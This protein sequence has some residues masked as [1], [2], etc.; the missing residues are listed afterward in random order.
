MFRT[1]A[2]VLSLSLAHVAGACGSTTPPTT[3]QHQ[4]NRPLSVAEHMAEAARHDKVAREHEDLSADEAESAAPPIQC[5]DN[6]LAPP[7]SSGGKQLRILRPCWTSVTRPSARH[8]SEA[9]EN[10]REAE[11]HRRAAAQ[12]IGAEKV[13]CAGLGVEATNHSPFYHREDIEGAQ[14][15][16][17][18]GELRGARVAFR[19][20][21]GLNVDWMRRAS[22]CHIARAGVMGYS[23]TFMPYCP[24]VIEGVVASV[25]ERAGAIEVELR[26]DDPVAAATIWGRV[27]RLT[28]GS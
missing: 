1:H 14:P 27:E 6:P 26:A 20:V 10:R 25:T 23:K 7:S 18:R 19:K 22:A 28:S 9:E 12:L 15:I 2:L 16:R 24:L 13:S 21:P 3:K 8:I 11:R 4:H 17:I 5:F